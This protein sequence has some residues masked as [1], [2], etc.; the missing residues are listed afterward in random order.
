MRRFDAYHS[1]GA[2]A[3]SISV[4]G[5]VARMDGC[6]AR[7]ASVSRYRACAQRRASLFRNV[8]T[9]SKRVGTDS[10]R[11]NVTLVPVGF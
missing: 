10:M 9:L 2:M 7:R 11:A 4:T 5:L 6:A 8:C 1:G 3:F